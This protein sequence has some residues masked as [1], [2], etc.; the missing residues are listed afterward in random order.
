MRKS[1][2]WIAGLPILLA[3]LACQPEADELAE[4]R[5]AQAE[6]L[7]RL[8]SLEERQN[9]LLGER[10]ATLPQRPPEDFERVYTIPLAD[11]PV[12]GNP[13]APVTIVEFAD[14]ECAFC[15]ETA[16]VLRAALEKYE[17][18]VRLVYKHF[19][20]SFHA[21]ARAAARASL[22]ALE[23]GRFWEMH[24]VL[25]ENRADL[26]EENLPR[27]AEEAGLDVGLF[28]TSY[29]SRKDRYERRIN[30]DYAS[31]LRAD[32]RG[33]P[34]VFVNGRKVRNRTLE[35]ISARIDEEVR[36]ASSSQ[37]NGS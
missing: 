17:N 20:L 23:Q 29:E 25:F 12:R 28:R 13:E 10:A 9:T 31:G 33:T 4:I 30:L 18:Q 1:R 8:A 14:F 16:P 36:K 3:V 26:K 21:Q 6:I 32:V 35:E 2:C 37:E 19:P 15:A 11:S 22:A 34:T 27:L 7:E 24:D 5:E